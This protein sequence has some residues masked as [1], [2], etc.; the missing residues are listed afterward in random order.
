MIFFLKFLIN[1]Q[2]VLVEVMIWHLIGKEN[3]I[4]NNYD[5]FLPCLQ[6]SFEL[7]D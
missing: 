3:I 5:R 6:A 4:C 1:G 7:I 2:W